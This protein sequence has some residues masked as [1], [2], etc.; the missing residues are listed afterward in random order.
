MSAGCLDRMLW[1][2]DAGG[3]VA[4]GPLRAHCRHRRKAGVEPAFEELTMQLG[5]KVPARKGQ[6]AGNEPQ[7]LGRAAESQGF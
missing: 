1:A 7:A 3:L 5:R 2:Q 6:T 4:T